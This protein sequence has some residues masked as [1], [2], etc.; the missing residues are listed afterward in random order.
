M[1]RVSFAVSAL[2]ACLFLTSPVFAQGGQA[3][4]ALVV[5]A[6]RV[7]L[8]DKPSTAGA[9]VVVLS[10]GDA[11]EVVETSGTWYRV[12]VKSS[13]KTGYVSN[14]FVQPAAGAPAAATGRAE[15]PATPPPAA[16]SAPAARSAD[17]A[18]FNQ[19]SSMRAQT[20]TSQRSR[21]VGIHAFVIAEAES[22]LAK[23]TFD[24]VLTKHAF[25]NAGFGVDITG[26]W[27]GLFARVDYVRTKNTGSRVFV[28]SA[29]GVHP[30]GI[31]IRVEIA[32]LEVGAGWRFKSMPHGD[33]SVV[34][35]VGAAVLMQSYQDVSDFADDP[36][37]TDTSDRGQTIFG[38]VEFGFRIARIG[39]EGFYR[40]VPNAI[41]TAGAS[42]VFGEKNLGGA[43]FR[44]TLGVGF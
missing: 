19:S 22:M 9:V 35:Y 12:R 17:P 28:D 8:R 21:R 41:G 4:Q 15:T 6:D 3:P 36:D 10:K 29:M 32:P 23:N 1:R 43:G 40:N 33:V 16:S 44:L 14:S 30:L 24:A 7:N 11:L 42:Q 27:K 13:G 34:P 2:V 39:V 25:T 18:P 20:S 38:G 26:L 31:P 37:N 5:N